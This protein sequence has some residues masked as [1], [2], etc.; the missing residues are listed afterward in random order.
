VCFGKRF[1]YTPCFLSNTEVV[2]EIRH[3]ERSC[4][5]V[6]GVFDTLCHRI[7]LVGVDL[8]INGEKRVHAGCLLELALY[9]PEEGL[10]IGDG[11]GVC[12]QSTDQSRKI[13]SIASCPFSEQPRQR[14]LSLAR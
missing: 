2:T 4:V 8:K 13:L 3:H 9:L 5:A 14:N 10:G 6:S 11:L 1:E 7:N 12:E